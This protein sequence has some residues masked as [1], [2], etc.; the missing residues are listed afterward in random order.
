M[1][2]A[3]VIYED[4]IAQCRRGMHVRDDAN[5][6]KGW[7]IE[8]C[9]EPKAKGPLEKR[10]GEF[11]CWNPIMKQLTYR[12]VPSKLNLASKRWRVIP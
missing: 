1:G 9:P 6:T 7:H 11:Y 2:H 12:F 10:V 5:M 4:A 3:V 8:F